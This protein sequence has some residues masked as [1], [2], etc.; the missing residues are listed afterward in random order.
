MGC[1]LL[2]RK[3]MT[4]LAL[5]ATILL[6]LVLV[7]CSAVQGQGQKKLE[8]LNP[9]NIDTMYHAVV[10]T[11]MSSDSL[12]F[13]VL[14]TVLKGKDGSVLSKTLTPPTSVQYFYANDTIKYGAENR[15]ALAELQGYARTDYNT[16]TI[17]VAGAS[18]VMAVKNMAMSPKD[19]GV[20]F[21]VTGFSLYLPDGTAKSYKLDTPIKAVITKDQKI[22]TAKGNPQFRADLQ[23]ASKGGAKFSA[24]AAPV[25][26]KDIDAKI[27]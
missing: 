2:R 27:K 11:G 22:M 24:N 15:T 19:G 25:K 1:I 17:D 20:E 23:D 21:Q 4:V 26:I 18:A 6:L 8:T 7:A 10:V 9:G 13:N 14:N 3:M 12:T 5:L 16:A